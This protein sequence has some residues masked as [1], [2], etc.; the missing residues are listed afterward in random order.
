[1]SESVSRAQNFR[2]GHVW[3]AA[4]Y[5]QFWQLHEGGAAAAEVLRIDPTNTTEKTPRP[6]AFK[7]QEA[8]DRYLDGLRKADIPERVAEQPR[9]L[10]ALLH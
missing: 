3:S 1:M 9:S 2:T 10:V 6:A 7:D 4:I 5:A 8:Q